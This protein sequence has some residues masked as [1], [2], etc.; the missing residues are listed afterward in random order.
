M[1]L[2]A[3]LRSR[4]KGFIHLREEPKIISF[5]AEAI[6]IP[7]VFFLNNLYLLWDKKLLIVLKAFVFQTPW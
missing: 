1:L 2:T 4:E 3:S 7:I 5:L 6:G